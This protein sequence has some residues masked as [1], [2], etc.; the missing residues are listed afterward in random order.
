MKNVYF[1]QVDVSASL[2]AQNAYLPYT[3]GI[4]AANAWTSGIVKQNFR[5]KEFIFLREN[6]DAGGDRIQQ[7]LLEHGIQ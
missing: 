6:I 2:G 5:F 7:L 3:A 1:V 4:L